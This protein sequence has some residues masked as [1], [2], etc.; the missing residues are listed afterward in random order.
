MAFKRKR[1][2]GGWYIDRV[3]SGK[4]LKRNGRGGRRMVKRSVRKVVRRKIASNYKKALVFRGANPIPDKTFATLKATLV[5]SKNNESLQ[6]IWD[7]VVKGN[8]LNQP[9]DGEDNGFNNPAWQLAQW[10]SRYY[11]RGSRCRFHV[12][13]NNGLGAARSADVW[14]QG[15]HPGIDASKYNVADLNW[16]VPST[17]ATRPEALEFCKYRQLCA[18]YSNA[19][20][21]TVR[22]QAT[23]T[24]ILNAKT[25]ALEDE[26]SGTLDYDGSKNSQTVNFGE[27]G[28]P[29]YWH[30]FCESYYQGSV[31]LGSMG[32]VV[33]I[34]MEWDTVFFRRHDR[35]ETVQEVADE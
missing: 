22:N 4:Y 20:F 13:P 23:T 25:N 17:G 19:Q 1:Y 16:N 35:Y 30:C 29:W 10:Y 3:R 11:V 7:V 6:W 2:G 24:K 28:K 31:A 21:S 15:V 33:K 32:A 26:Y 14:F 18:S 34:D 8:S 5:T 9:F 12:I 27:V